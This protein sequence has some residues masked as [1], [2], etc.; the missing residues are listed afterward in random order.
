MI[1]YIGVSKLSCLFCDLVF[2][3]Y[4]QATDT[5][6]Y[7]RGTHSQTTVWSY[8]EFRQDSPL[9]SKIKEIIRGKLLSKINRDWVRL[10]P[11]STGSNSTDASDDV[12]NY[13]EGVFFDW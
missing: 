2:A 8:V 4:R 5:L 6:V 11:H 12:Q 13:H 9:N 1:P 3:A 7:T 10:R